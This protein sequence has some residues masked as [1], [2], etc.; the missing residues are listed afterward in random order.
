M[1][2]KSKVKQRIY[3]REYQRTRRKALKEQK[4]ALDKQIIE[5]LNKPDVGD[6]RHWPDGSD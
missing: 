1:A 2:Y 3:N 4:E 5:M 6:I